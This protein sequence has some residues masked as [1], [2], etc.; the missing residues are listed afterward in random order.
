MIKIKKIMVEPIVEALKLGIVPIV[1][2]DIIMD[3]KMAVVSFREKRAW[4]I[5]Y[6][7]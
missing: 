2:G 6:Q 1:F 7:S 5:C 3:T 4:I